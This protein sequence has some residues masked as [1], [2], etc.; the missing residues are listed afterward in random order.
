MKYLSFLLLCVWCYTSSH[1]QS[2]KYQKLFIHGKALPNT[3]VY[4][5]I[6]TVKYPN[7]P[8]AVKNLLVQPAGLFVSFKTNSAFISAKWCVTAKNVSLNMTAIANKGLDLYIKK[9]NKWQF[10]GIGRPSATCSEGKLVE[11][12]DNSV[13]ECLLY[14]PV[15]DEVKNLEIGVSTDAI[16]EELPNPFQ[17]KILVY[18]SS[19]V[20]G[21]SASRPGMAYPARL[22]RSTGLNFINLGLSGNAKM[23]SSVANML[24]GIAAD[25]YILDCVPNS[26]PVE[27][28]QRT[29]YLVNSI[30]N[31]RPNAPIIV[32]QSVI[33]EHG[34]W[35]QTVGNRVKAQNEQI[36]EEVANL[37][38]NGVE[39]LYLITADN[40]LGNDH[41]AT[42]DGTHP[43]DL[44]FDRILQKLQPAILGILTQHGIYDPVPAT[45]IST[46][47]IITGYNA[48]PRGI[49]TGIPGTALGSSGATH[50][51]G[52]DYMQF[53]AT[54]DIDFSVTP[55]TV[56]VNTNAGLAQTATP[57]Y[58]VNGWITGGMRTYKLNLT[59]GEVKKDK[60]FYVG[61][62]EKRINGS[63]NGVKSTDISETAPIATN[64]AN[65]IRAK[66]YTAEVGDNNQHNN[67][68]P[69]PLGS[70][71]VNSGSAMALLPGTGA[72]AGFAIF[73]GINVTENS[74]PL[75]AIF[76]NVGNGTNGITN[77]NMYDATGG[78]GLRVPNNDLYSNVWQP[79][80]GQGS[81]N[82]SKVMPSPSDGQFCKLG[83]VYDL[84]TRTW[85]TARSANY[86]I[87][88]QNA[89]LSVI[90][91]GDV[92]VLPA[93]FSSFT[94]KLENKSVKLSWM[95]VSE[96]ND[97]Y[98][99][100]L[101]SIDGK[102]FINIG[103]VRRNDKLSKG[104]SYSFTDDTPIQGV[105]YYK[106][107]QVGFDNGI[108]NSRVIYITTETNKSTLS[109]YTKNDAIHVDT[110][111]LKDKKS[112]LVI[113]D[114]S[115][116]KI[117]QQGLE[118]QK[119]YN[120]ITIPATL[121]AGIYVATLP[122]D[123]ELISVK[124]IK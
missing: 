115:G 109:V 120:T 121:P 77:A 36:A 24:S 27:I 57:G 6:D 75:D 40:L 18:G 66:A 20:Q 16:L 49:N 104:T 86:F 19:I 28:E 30:R 112:R 83:G 17:K 59:S 42:I 8:L 48:D 22:S 4:H 91:T 61:G 117:L 9:D 15:W 105:N 93:R 113:T 60:F 43:N 56:I 44:G 50:L 46:P 23:E 52:F 123:S 13:K 11:N 100:V 87:P 53:M 98:F 35:N 47:V 80:M 107:E 122:S 108:S 55:Y 73:S 95:T 78:T 41:E 85:T 84:E 37:Q 76:L 12:M 29:A 79:F 58:L 114:I 21:A 45:P 69:Q 116:K 39:N 14:L 64:R 10:A 51:G 5:R 26:L 68:A 70:I 25:A 111:S 90:E 99:N 33:R 67:N 1:A 96:Q 38:N 82:I 32:I 62:M 71:K 92:T 97:N 34:Y 65:W 63:L 110:Y 31:R 94:G 7:I 119:G 72:T 3:N 2:V 124:F 106:L 54:E 88:A 118:L 103:T 102:E 81:N 74:I 89:P 101:R